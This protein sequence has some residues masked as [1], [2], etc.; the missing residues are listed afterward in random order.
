MSRLALSQT[1]PETNLLE[2]RDAAVIGVLFETRISR[3]QLRELKSS[4]Y[5][6][7]KK[8]LWLNA[9]E[10]ITLSDKTINALARWIQ[11]LTLKTGF[12][13]R[14][15]SHGT[16]ISNDP[17]SAQNVYYILNKHGLLEEEK[18]IPSRRDQIKLPMASVLMLIKE[19]I[20][21]PETGYTPIN[22]RYLR[23]AYGLSERDVAQ[24]LGV[25][26]QTVQRWEITDE[27]SLAKREM[28]KI[29]WKR[30][31]SALLER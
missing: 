26:D 25:S 6:A 21:V 3:T 17:L 19:K 13:F 7:K 27:D 8:T 31:I 20:T 9:Q 24:I 15:I 29:M 12:L 22:L 11:C 10:I 5:D 4:Q 28:S 16:H 2:A 18:Q 14:H 23:I 1:E 30:F